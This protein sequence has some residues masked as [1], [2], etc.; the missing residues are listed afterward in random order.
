MPLADLLDVG[1]LLSR[2]AEP[3]MDIRVLDA[4]LFGK[5][6]HLDS[7][8]AGRLEGGKDPVLESAAGCPRSFAG[9]FGGF[10][11]ASPLFLGRTT[12][13]FALGCASDWL[14]GDQGGE[15]GFDFPDLRKQALLTLGQFNKPF[16]GLAVNVC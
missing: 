16:Q 12:P 10:V 5:V 9:G 8:V 4:D 11:N 14:S 3:D 7:C 2:G 15:L 13:A 1:V 6:G